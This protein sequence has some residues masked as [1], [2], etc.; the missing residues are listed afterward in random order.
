MCYS[1]CAGTRARTVTRTPQNVRTVRRADRTPKSG[2]RLFTIRYRYLV[3]SVYKLVSE[4][5]DPFISKSTF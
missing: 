3:V 1:N 2:V 4:S 5:D